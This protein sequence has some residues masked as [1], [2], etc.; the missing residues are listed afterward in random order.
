MK[1]FTFDYMC[2][3]T[4]DLYI[5]LHRCRCRIQNTVLYWKKQNKTFFTLDKFDLSSLNFKLLALGK[6]KSIIKL[7]HQ[8]VVEANNS[9]CKGHAW[10]AYVIYSRQHCLTWSYFYLS[11][12][13]K[14]VFKC[15]LNF[16]FSKVL[17]QV[18]QKVC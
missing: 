13:S 5:T 9:A 18:S 10:H 7:S 3:Y 11:L 17:S 15:S 2:V 16:H 4:V 1:V 12:I 14:I 8:V 6:G